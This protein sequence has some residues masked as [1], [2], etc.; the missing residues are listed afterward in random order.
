MKLFDG[1]DT[2]KTGANRLD[3]DY[4]GGSEQDRLPT[5]NRS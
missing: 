1:G 5:L 4:D 2:T 3:A